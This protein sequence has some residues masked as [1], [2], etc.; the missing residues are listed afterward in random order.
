MIFALGNVMT[1]SQ[2]TELK[3]L[4]ILSKMQQN[5]NKIFAIKPII[6]AISKGI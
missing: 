1:N 5:Q 3:M 2:L 4:L 6:L